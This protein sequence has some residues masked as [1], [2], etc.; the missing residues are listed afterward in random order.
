MDSI[1]IFMGKIKIQNKTINT[2]G[3]YTNGIIRFMGTIQ[4]TPSLCLCEHSQNISY[5]NLNRDVGLEAC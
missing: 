5:N 2:N 1:I 4:V 3:Q